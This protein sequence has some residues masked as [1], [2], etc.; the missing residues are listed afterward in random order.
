[1]AEAVEAPYPRRSYAWTVVG[2]LFC[3]AVL[4][5]TDRQVLSL[6]VDPVRAE[7]HI[8]DTQMSLLLGL[9]FA[10]IYGAAGIPLGWLADRTS[11]RNL[12]LA[13][14]V[15][16]GIGTLLCG[17]A[18]SFAALFG[19]RIIVGLGEAV[20]SPAAVSLISD[21]FPPERR[22]RAVG[23]Y[24]A[25]I[26][27]GIGGSIFLGGA[28]LNLVTGGLLAGT[29][30]ASLPAW[31]AVF[32]VIGAPSLLWALVMLAVREPARRLQEGAETEEPARPA[33]V[34]WRAVWAIAPVYAAVAI[35]SLV[36]N[37]VGAWAPSLLIRRFHADPAAVGVN[38][39][40]LLMLGYGGGMLVG[41]W[42][43]DRA[44]ALRGRRGKIELCLLAALL[45]L[46]LSAALNVPSQ[47]VVMAATAVYFA[48]S[49]VVTAAGLSAILDASPNRVRGLAMAISFFLNV[50]IGAG[51]GPTAVA[52]AGERVVGEA[53]GLGPAIALTVAACY[54][55]A[56]A[57]LVV[58]R[59]T[60]EAR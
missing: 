31:R 23:V 29:P 8:S 22:G 35:A 58:G 26:A 11:R 43:A 28:I 7:L 3:T 38:L 59:K 54:A 18:H 1:M 46:P 19:A 45:I 27:V 2:I 30:L 41:G 13:G 32:V 12:I 36:D 53:A 17:M 48:V 57:A 47:S 6:L 56:A 14:V 60:A 51:L 24:F 49:A 9:A 10:F 44:A 20:L 39:G 33:G 40:I 42:L 4:S 52:L 37:A 34:D 15:V 16:W 25:G 21:Y 55:L 50:A 5:Y